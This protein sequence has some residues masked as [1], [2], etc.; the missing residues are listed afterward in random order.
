MSN[1]IISNVKERLLIT[2]ITIE[3]QLIFVF[4]GFL[5][6]KQKHC[7]MFLC[8]DFIR[9]FF[10]FFFCHF[11]VTGI[12]QSRAFTECISKLAMIKQE[13]NFSLFRV[14]KK[15]SLLL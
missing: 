6:F 2:N 1:N 13:F 5:T 11:L 3:I 14:S 4:P 12:G 15:T 9:I 10:S 8:E 7:S